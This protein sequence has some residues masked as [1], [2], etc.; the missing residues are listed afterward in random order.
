MRQKLRTHTHSYLTSGRRLRFTTQNRYTRTYCIPTPY[1]S[2]RIL[3]C[4]S[5]TSPFWVIL[6]L[7]LLPSLQAKGLRV[8]IKQERSAAASLRFRFSS[9]SSTWTPTCLSSSSRVVAEEHRNRGATKRTKKKRAA[10]GKETML[11]R[12]SHVLVWLLT[13]DGLCGR[14]FILVVSAEQRRR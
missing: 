5:Y 8:T 1:T 6:L 7:S 12:S 14:P 3:S 10:L 9:T 2:T 13:G 11:A 4:L